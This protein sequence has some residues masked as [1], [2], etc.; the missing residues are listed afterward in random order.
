MAIQNADKTNFKEL[1]AQDFVIVDFYGNACAP[2]KLFSRIL[3]DMEAE[4]PFLNIVKLNTTE[5]PE[6]ADEY[7]IS[8]VPSI[9]FY[10]D[11]QL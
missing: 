1:I 6:I 9:L 3:E 4:I 5:H 10:H 7:Q 8:A 11:G 2:C